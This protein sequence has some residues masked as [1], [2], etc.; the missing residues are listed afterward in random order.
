M[1]R[2]RI[3]IFLV[4]LLVFGFVNAQTTGDYRTAASSVT[5]STAG[6]WQTWDGSQWVTA[7]AAPG[8]S[9]NV[10]IQAGHTATLAG[11]QSC[12]DLYISTGTSNSSTGGDGQI[13]LQSNT[14]SVNGK[15]S[16]YIG[17]VDVAVS[18]SNPLSI[19]ADATT[20]S[21]PISKTSGGVLKFVGN[22]RNI[23]VSGEWSGNASGSTSLFDIEIALS[24][25]QIG[26]LNTVVK[27]AKW[28]ISSGTL[29]TSLRISADNNTTGQGNF[30][31]NT[32]AIFSS[33]E[34]GGGTTPVISRT[35]TAICGTVTINGI[36]RLS[37]A[38]PHIQCAAYSLGSN[39]TI[40][41]SRSNSTGNQTFLNHSFTNADSLV[42]YNH[43]I[44]S[45]IGTK[46]TL[47]SSHTT[48]SANGSLT[49][50]GGAL[51][52][53]SGGS[54]S[55]NSTGTTLI[56]SGTSSQTASTTEWY[57][58][59]QNLTINNS[60]GLS[61][62]FARTI[63]GKLTLTSGTFTNGANLTLGNGATIARTGGLINS[64]PTFGSTVNVI[65]NENGSNITTG[66]E[67]PSST[68]VLNNV[69]INTS[70]GV[71][72]NS[73]KTINGLLT[74]SSGLLTT[75][76]SNLLTLGTSG[77]VSGATS[78]KFINGPVAKNTNSTSTFTF[79]TGKG[80]ILRTIAVTP[81]N[82]NP[83][84]Y[85]AEYFNNAY[86]NITSFTSPITRVSSIDYFELTR[87]ASGT[88]SDAAITLEWGSNSGVNTSNVNELTLSRYAGGGWLNEAATGSGDSSS[89][90]LITNSAVSNFGTF[91]IANATT[92]NNLL[93]VKLLSFKINDNKLEWITANELNNDGF[94]ILASKIGKDFY[95]I[96]YVKSHAVG[97][98]SHQI[99]IYSY[100]LDGTPTCN[101]YYRIKQVDFNGKYEFSKIVKNNY[102]A[103]DR[104]TIANKILFIYCLSGTHNICEVSTLNGHVMD[105]YFQ[106]DIGVFD[107]TNLPVGLYYFSINGQKPVKFFNN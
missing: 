90:T 70:N 82:T 107:L 105:Q 13:A 19:T 87:S 61:L 45:G 67:L 101:S 11:N 10:F 50:N 26:T 103:N 65:Y 77:S 52:V 12:N 55:V 62:G 38:S 5:W 14:L 94:E 89:G 56:Y 23:T 2:L 60:S 69:T 63:N 42:V 93:P 68:S 7:S 64:A 92:N 40:E 71:T 47:A 34:S 83:T 57:T 59:F 85:S 106:N 97:G 3:T 32:G 48:I 1:N 96:G 18:S 53:G 76:A 58:N 24:A 8:A 20:P 74:F 78:S 9:N 35:T 6:D 15:L 37:G 81:S 99:L 46:T 100:L 33:S 31:I 16:C 54:F 29:Q 27:A 17:V 91:S 84:T 51:G 88:P 72:L 95:P 43:I 73:A 21:L 49:M 104:W 75:T 86:V 25:G 39:G 102:N 98:N 4:N 66:N 36:L 30:T 79:P 22:T 41:Y 80:S 44:L 28:L